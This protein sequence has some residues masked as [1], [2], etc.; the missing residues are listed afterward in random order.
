MGPVINRIKGCSAEIDGQVFTFE[1]HH[2]G[3]LTQHSGNTGMHRKVWSIADHGPDFVVLKL[4]LADGLGGFPGN[5]EIELRYTVHQASISMTVQAITDAPTPFNPANHSYWSLD[6]TVGFS[7]Q[8]FQVH[9]DHY[10]EPDE[11]LMP[12][13]Q[14]LPVAGSQYDFR[15]GSIMAGDNSQFYD[16]NFCMADQKRPLTIVA[17]L[18]GTEGVRMEMA[19]TECG[20]QL[21]DG[22]TIHAPGHGTHHGASYDP[23]AAPALEAQSWPGSLDHAHFPDIIL[24][25]GARYEQITSWTFSAEGLG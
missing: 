19:T 16:F 18:T 21:Y 10:S 1:K 8:T 11:N 12:T 22:G 3:D 9:S 4:A 15:S 14:I 25:P 7:G 17:T 13:G 2:S 5:R 6:P 23:Y 24:R 20:L